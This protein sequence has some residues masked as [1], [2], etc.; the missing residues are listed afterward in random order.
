M[1]VVI[2]TSPMGGPTTPRIATCQRVDQKGLRQSLGG[3]ASLGEQFHRSSGNS[4]EPVKRK[5]EGFSAWLLWLFRKLEFP[6]T[7]LDFL[8]H[9]P[10]C[11]VSHYCNMQRH[12]DCWTISH[13]L[14]FEA[15]GAFGCKLSTQCF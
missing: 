15:K 5:E 9:L 10:L 6:F 3:E 4:F 13:K 1:S 12:D 11:K 7:S 2:S 8:C 14:D